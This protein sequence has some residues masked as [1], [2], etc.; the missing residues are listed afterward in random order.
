MAA[1]GKRVTVSSSEVCADGTRESD[2]QPLIL[3]RRSASIL[4]LP[5][6]SGSPARTPLPDSELQP[7][8]E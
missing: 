5:N 4:H 3:D 1:T 2:R 8:D 6:T 7:E